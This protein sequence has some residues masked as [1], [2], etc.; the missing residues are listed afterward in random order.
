MTAVAFARLSQQS[1]GAFSVV[2]YSIYGTPQRQPEK[3]FYG[4]VQTLEQA[5]S[6]LRK[7]RD[8]GVM[9]V[10]AIGFDPETANMRKP[11]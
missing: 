3:V 8:A 6:E 10:Y 2:A 1:R 9:D 7:L 5:A 4:T 11:P